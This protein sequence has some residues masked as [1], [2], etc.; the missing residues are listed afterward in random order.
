MFLV[1]CGIETRGTTRHWYMRSEPE[2][3]FMNISVRE[4]SRSFSFWSRVSR[5]DCQFRG[6]GW[7]RFYC[8]CSKERLP[9]ACWRARRARSDRSCWRDLSLPGVRNTVCARILLLPMI[10]LFHGGQWI[11]F[12]CIPGIVAFFHSANLYLK[13]LVRYIFCTSV[14]Y[15]ELSMNP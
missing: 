9:K 1:C 2:N 4:V 6:R 12:R 3:A 8:R 5:S 11:G 14:T 15:K 10:T 7:S 13:R